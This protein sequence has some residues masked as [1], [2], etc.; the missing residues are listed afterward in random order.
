MDANEEKVS[1]EWSNLRGHFE[2]SKKTCFSGLQ[3]SPKMQVHLTLVVL[4][5]FGE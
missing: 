1:T 4:V 2:L 5:V 3:L